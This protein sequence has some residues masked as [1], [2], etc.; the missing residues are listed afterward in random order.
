MSETRDVVV[1]VIEA[2]ADAD[3]VAPMDLEYTLYDYVDPEI[4]AA[5]AALEDGRWS[6]TFEV[7]VHEVTIES[8]GRLFV[9]GVLCQTDLPMNG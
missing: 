2:L 3:R 1:E 9:D 5:L 6:F 4:L 8:D 7:D